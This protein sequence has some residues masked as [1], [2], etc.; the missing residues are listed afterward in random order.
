MKVPR[1][2][3]TKP[4]SGFSN[5]HGKRGAL[6]SR[7]SSQHQDLSR[8]CRFCLYEKFG[9]DKDW[10]SVVKAQAGD[11]IAINGSFS[12]RKWFRLVLSGLKFVAW[13][14]DFLC[15]SCRPSKAKAGRKF[16]PWS[17]GPE[18]DH[19][20]TQTGKATTNLTA[21]NML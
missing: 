16:E 18:H 17:S 4:T 15:N 7:Y 9:I 10:S 2:K 21:P 11:S 19:K 8:I 5:T 13:F 12:N 14:C 3:L 6:T 1:H 20:N